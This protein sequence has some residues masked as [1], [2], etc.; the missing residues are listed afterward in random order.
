MDSLDWDLSSRVLVLYDNQL[1]L[2]HWI[3]LP[4]DNRKPVD[5]KVSY[6]DAESCCMVRATMLSCACALASSVIRHVT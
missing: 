2:L 6:K 4:S 1:A 5:L 3:T